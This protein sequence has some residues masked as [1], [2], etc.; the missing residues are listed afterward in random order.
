MLE[1]LIAVLGL[2][3]ATV[4][5]ES[6]CDWV[7]LRL[8]QAAGVKVIELPLAVD[9]SLDPELLARLLAS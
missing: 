2:K 1:I 7:I 9:G 4:L 3:G 5:V 6:P 8:L